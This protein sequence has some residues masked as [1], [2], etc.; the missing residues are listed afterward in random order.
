[1]AKFCSAC[2]TPLID[3]A[4][5]CP[6][7]G[8]AVDHATIENPVQPQFDPQPPFSAGQQV[9]P[10]I[11]L[12]GDG[13]Y[14][15]IYE[16]SLYKNPTIFLLVWKIFIVIA[17]GIFLFVMLMDALNGYMDT[18]RLLLDLKIL[19]YVFIGVTALVAISCLI[20]AAIMGGKYIVLFTMDEYGINHA[21]IPTQAKKARSIAA[22]AFVMGAASGSL[23]GMAGG[24]AAAN[25]EMYTSFAKTRKVRFYPRRDII[26]IRQVLFR[27][28]IYAKPEDFNFVQSYILARVPD[29]AKPKNMRQ[30]G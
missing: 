30:Q 1:M 26:K 12:G 25:T 3:G 19:A 21:Q 14:R 24:L 29:Q 20:Y 11:T 8:K 27:N 6:N 2:G 13:K 18:E 23:G 16:M 4:R 5:F 9:T 15:W 17:L 10:N 28:Q 7:C 22:A